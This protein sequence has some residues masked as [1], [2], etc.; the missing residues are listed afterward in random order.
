MANKQGYHNTN[1]KNYIKL[2]IMR[3][4]KFEQT[5]IDYC[6]SHG[7]N[8]EELNQE[9]MSIES[10]IL[11]GL[12]SLGPG[13]RAII[14]ADAISMRNEVEAHAFYIERSTTIPVEE[15]FRTLHT[16]KAVKE[17]VDFLETLLQ[18]NFP[19][20][21][22]NEL[23]HSILFSNQVEETSNPIIEELT[24]IADAVSL[25][26]ASIQPEIP[27]NE[28]EQYFTEVASSTSDSYPDLIDGMD[29]GLAMFLYERK[30]ELTNN[31]TQMPE[32]INNPEALLVNGM[33]PGLAAFLIQARESRVKVLS[34]DDQPFT[35]EDNFPFEQ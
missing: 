2:S 1:T 27:Q 32:G 9:R 28:D 22:P 17:G 14:F 3:N 4:A 30:K 25:Q 35:Q 24:P 11:G 6:N 20:E 13:S 16:C 12:T 15:K 23:I 5:N 26:D 34:K 33:D 10:G 31:F 19:H 8:W 29:P 21:F 7:K 18:I